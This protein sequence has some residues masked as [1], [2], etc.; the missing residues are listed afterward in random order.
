MMINLVFLMVGLINRTAIEDQ[1]V[2]AI[3]HAAQDI[4]Y[5]HTKCENQYDEVIV[6]EISFCKLN[7]SA[8]RLNADGT[9]NV[10]FGLYEKDLNLIFL[11][12]EDPDNFLVLF[13]EFLHYMFYYSLDCKFTGIGAQQQHI[14]I[15]EMV[16]QYMKLINFP[17]RTNWSWAKKALQNDECLMRN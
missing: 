4:F 3:Y 14:M 2:D 12:K 6:A 5:T 10:V 1:K 7:Q 9:I 15:N 11:S 16:N 13:H 17:E 8:A